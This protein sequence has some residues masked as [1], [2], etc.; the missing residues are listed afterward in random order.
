MATSSALLIPLKIPLPI[1]PPPCHLSDKSTATCLALSAC[2]PPSTMLPPLLRCHHPQHLDRSTGNVTAPDNYVKD[3]PPCATNIFLEC[4]TDD[5]CTLLANKLYN[6]FGLNNNEKLTTSCGCYA[7]S[8]LLPLY[9]TN[10]E[11]NARDPCYNPVVVENRKTLCRERDF[12]G[13]NERYKACAAYVVRCWLPEDGA[14]GGELCM[15]L[16]K[17]AVA[18]LVPKLLQV[19]C[20]EMV[21]SSRMER[22]SVEILRASWVALVL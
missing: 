20:L 19:R 13:E 14:A 6:S 15:I 2:S 12:G 17:M 3:P 16:A 18:E 10:G 7:E 1:P 9:E 22:V 4:E 8:N 21:A 11:F 5:N